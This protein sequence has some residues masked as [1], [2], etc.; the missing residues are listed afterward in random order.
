MPR[1]HSKGVFQFSGGRNVIL[2]GIYLLKPS[3]ALFLLKLKVTEAF[4]S[5]MLHE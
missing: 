4:H 3:L 2:E 1:G 5:W